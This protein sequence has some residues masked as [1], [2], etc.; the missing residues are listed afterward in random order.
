MEEHPRTVAAWAGLIDEFR[1]AVVEL[2]ERVGTLHEH[3]ECTDAE[4][5]GL[6]D[7]VTSGFDKLDFR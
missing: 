6:G 3:C 4:L 5:R 2:Q 7:L 1:K